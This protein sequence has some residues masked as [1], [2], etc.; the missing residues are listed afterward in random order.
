M[1]PRKRATQRQ[2]EPQPQTEGEKPSM[3]TTPT[4]T[5]M[6]LTDDVLRRMQQGILAE[7]NNGAHAA[8]Q[9]RVARSDAAQ[10]DADLRAAEQAHEECRA[11]LEKL[12]ADINKFATQAANARE[13][14][15]QQTNIAT[16]ADRQV[17]QVTMMINEHR[18]EDRPA[19]AVCEN[20]RRPMV[21]RGSAWGHDVE[22]FPSE[23]TPGHPETTFA[24][25][26][27]ASAPVQPDYSVTPPNGVPLPASQI[28]NG[29]ETQVLAPVPPIETTDGPGLVAALRTPTAGPVS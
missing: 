27:G 22:G 8:E 3:M 17:S 10:F 23:C 19:W 24:T 25:P 9:A 14:D 18:G 28:I 2:D 6:V 11:K 29:P 5:A 13:V 7:A 26:F 4:R 15:R 1:S 16:A 12:Q 20:C 21:K